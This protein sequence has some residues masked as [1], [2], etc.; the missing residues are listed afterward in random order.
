MPLWSLHSEVKIIPAKTGLGFG[1]PPRARL[2]E[3]PPK[4]LKPAR[5]ARAEAHGGPPLPK[6]VLDGRERHQRLG[7][8]CGV[9]WGG[10]GQSIKVTQVVKRPTELS[11]LGT[12]KT[13]VK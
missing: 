10:V 5:Q 6:V 13:P 3:A 4:A 8:G 2:A 7:E 9:G 12:W 11:R 1:T